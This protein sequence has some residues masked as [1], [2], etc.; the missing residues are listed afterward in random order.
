MSVRPSIARSHG[1]GIPVDLACNNVESPYVTTYN[2]RATY[3][4]YH[5]VQAEVHKA[6]ITQT[7]C[8]AEVIEAGL[9][10][11]KAYDRGIGRTPYTVENFLYLC[12]PGTVQ[13]RSGNI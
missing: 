8:T 10:G 4:S 1:C 6:T 3:V 12:C 7:K 13:V 11:K 2:D 5:K 9:T